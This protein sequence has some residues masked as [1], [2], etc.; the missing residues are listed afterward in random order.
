MTDIEALIAGAHRDRIAAFRYLAWLDMERRALVSELHPE[1]KPGDVVFF[2]SDTQVD[3]LV[4]GASPLERAVPVLEAI[5]IDPYTDDCW[6][7]TL[8]INPRDI[9]FAGTAN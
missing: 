3:S 7:D 1:H 9:P 8:D 2:P 4:L 5:G 6:T